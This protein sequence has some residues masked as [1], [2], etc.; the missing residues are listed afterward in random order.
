MYKVK[1]IPSF[2]IQCNINII[3]TPTLVQEIILQLTLNQLFSVITFSTSKTK[4]SST[5]FMYNYGVK[6][7]RVVRYAAQLLSP[8]VH[9]IS[10]GAALLFRVFRNNS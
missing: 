3:R 10:V 6:L 1:H 4:L 2:F 8:A 7:K 9:P 5:H